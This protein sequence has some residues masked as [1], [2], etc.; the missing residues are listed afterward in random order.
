[1]VITVERCFLLPSTHGEYINPPNG[2]THSP[3]SPCFG[4]T[5]LILPVDNFVYVERCEDVNPPLEITDIVADTDNTHNTTI[6]VT[7]TEIAAG[8]TIVVLIATG[9]GGNVTGLTDGINTFT[10]FGGS[11]GGYLVEVWYC[12][13]PLH[14]P[15]GTT[16]TAT[17]SFASESKYIHVF[18]L[19]KTASIGQ[20]NSSELLQ[21]PSVATDDPVATESAVFAMTLGGGSANA[22]TQPAGWS[23]V[24][25]GVIGLVSAQPFDCIDGYK[26]TDTSGVQTYTPSGYPVFILNRAVIATFE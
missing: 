12:L 11:V 10:L 21:P 9:D 19:N 1:M 13:S 18:T 15:N 22:L 26:V 16:L 7:L 8:D 20:V 23:G 4:A 2:Q 25:V 17:F 14:V 3:F 24:V 5:D 6:S